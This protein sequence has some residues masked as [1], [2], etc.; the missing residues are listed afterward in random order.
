MFLVL[1]RI[2]AVLALG[3]I[4]ELGFSF[5]W[6]F[7]SRPYLQKGDVKVML[8]VRDRGPYFDPESYLCQAVACPGIVKDSSSTVVVDKPPEAPH[9]AEEKTILKAVAKGIFSLTTAIQRC[10]RGP[11]LL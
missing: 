3:Q 9:L 1:D 8:H 5:F 10:S 11:Q 7:G 6:P 2:P 4:I